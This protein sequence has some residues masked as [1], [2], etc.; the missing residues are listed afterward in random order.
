MAKSPN[1]GCMSKLLTSCSRLQLYDSQSLTVNSVFHIQH[2]I[3]LSSLEKANFYI[4]NR[5]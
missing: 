3:E 5:C 1:E 2:I 4:I